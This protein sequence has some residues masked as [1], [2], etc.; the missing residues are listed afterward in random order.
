VESVER[1]S[2]IRRVSQ[3]QAQALA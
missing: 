1:V 3:D 2:S